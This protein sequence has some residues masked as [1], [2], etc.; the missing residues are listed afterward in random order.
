VH[1]FVV[2]I[3][4]N[5]FVNETPDRLMA[6]QIRNQNQREE[7]DGGRGREGTKEESEIRT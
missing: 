1:H 7:R 6:D 4:P 3:L 2:R 5:L